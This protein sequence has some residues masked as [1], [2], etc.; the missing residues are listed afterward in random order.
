MPVCGGGVVCCLCV[1]SAGWMICV[2]W[3]AFSSVIGL[4]PVIAH[5]LYRASIQN[6]SEHHITSERAVAKFATCASVGTLGS[7]DGAA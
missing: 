7:S 4:K 2:S 6:T 1:V 3:L 5:H